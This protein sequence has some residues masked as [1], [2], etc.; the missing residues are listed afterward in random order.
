MKYYVKIGRFYHAPFIDE[1]FAGAGTPNLSLDPETGYN[2][3]I[4][5]EVHIAQEWTAS[6]AVYD[7]EMQ[8]E[9]YYDPYAWQNKNSPG[10]TRRVGLDASL[11]WARDHVAGVSFYYSAVESEFTEGPYD[12]NA[13]P[14]VP[15]HTVG[16]N[17]EYYLAH[18]VAVMGGFRYVTKQYL[19][20]DFNNQADELK[21]CPLFDCGVRYEPS[22]LK[23][24]RVT[25]G[26]DNL[27]GREH[28]DYA[29][30]ASGYAYYYPSQGRFWK[31]GA[32]YTF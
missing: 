20:S 23:G 8:N 7:M 14:L 25:L 17:G 31:L 18:D 16:L 2:M 13:M 28:C 1:I 9:I 15:R 5:T 32:S 12:G 11:R 30:Y 29:G 21:A 24:L 26:V 4:G 3:E 6:L 27:F 22:F 10:D 19:G